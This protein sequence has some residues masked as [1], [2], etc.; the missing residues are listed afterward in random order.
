MKKSILVFVLFF[1]MS[2]IVASCKDSKK[3][4]EKEV[5]VEQTE[6]GVEKADL[7]MN[8]AYVCPMG[9]EGDKTYDKE[10]KC[11]VCEMDMKKVEKEESDA[12]HDES[13]EYD[14]DDSEGE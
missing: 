13:V 12:D 14:H 4:S 7:A 9:C 6:L 1:S 10:G 3:Q 11:P 8:D 2:I 5:G